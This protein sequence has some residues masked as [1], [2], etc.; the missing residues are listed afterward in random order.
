MGHDAASHTQAPVVRLHSWPVPHGEQAAPA[1][2]HDTFDSDAH[3]WHVPSA[4]QHPLGHDFASQTQPPVGLQSWPAGHA[5]HA[6]PP[7]PQEELDS[8][9]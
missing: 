5:A 3:A 4:A 2:P 6:A 7:L 9:E 8:P 1:V